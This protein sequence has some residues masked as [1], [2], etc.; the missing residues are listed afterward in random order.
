[1]FVFAAAV[2]AVGVPVSAGDAKG[3]APDTSLTGIVELAV[4]AD[5][6]FPFTYPVNVVAPV[7]PFAKATVPVTF[8]AVPVIFPPGIT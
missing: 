1:M 2:G 3:A 6:P 4:I 8:E 7:P 5:V